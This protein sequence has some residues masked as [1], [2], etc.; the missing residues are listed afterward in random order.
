M[1]SK[2]EPISSDDE[3]NHLKAIPWCAKHL[4]APN[5]VIA[6]VFSREPSTQF[7]DSFFSQTI[8]TRDTV[9]ALVCFYPR[10]NDERNDLLPE[11]KTLAA[12]GSLVNGYTGI[13]HGGVVASIFDEILSL[14]HP[15]S[16]WRAYK[17]GVQ[18]VVTAYLNTT[19]LKPVK[20]PGT[21]LFTV[22]LNRAEGRK[23]FVEGIME[24]EHGQK[25]A[26]AEAMFIETREK[27]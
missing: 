23:I 20:T 4:A 1:T 15:G 16:R 21:Y 6:P 13:C 19:Y 18:S 24:D 7:E 5:L 9:P 2:S 8:K 11:L 22:R 14:I 17:T 10:P 26:R 27:L 12:L 3:I 25:L